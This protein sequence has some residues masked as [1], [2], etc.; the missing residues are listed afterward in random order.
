MV[1]FGAT[2][3]ADAADGPSVRTARARL[4]AARVESERAAL[5]YLSNQAQLGRIEA[6]IGVL[7]QRIPRVELRIRELRT[8]LKERAAVLYRGGEGAGVAVVDTVL[9]GGDL[10]VGGRIA[11]LAGVAH[12]DTD[13]AA[14]ELDQRKAELTEDQ[15]ELVTVRQLQQ[16]LVEDSFAHSQALV[17]KVQRAEGELWRAEQRQALAHY[18]AAVAAQRA[19]HEAA[20]A[21]AAYNG[22]PPP[23]PQEQS[24]PGDPALAAEI[25]VSTLVCPIDGLV[26]FVDDWGQPRSSWRVHQGTD[27][28]NARS[29]PNL[30]VANGV[31]RMRVG[32]LGGNSIWLVTDDGH[33]YYYAHLERFE[34]Q[35][36]PDGTRRVV[37]GDVVGYSGNTGNAAG[38]PVHTHFQIH[39]RAGG[40]I[41]PYAPLREMCK[42]QAGLVPPED[43]NALATTTTLPAPV[44]T[45]STLP[46]ATT[47]TPTTAEGNGS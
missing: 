25:P 38:G 37:R 9:R 26:T 30:A 23:E 45:T 14:D 31:A 28:F 10:M 5:T 13:A 4:E 17:A 18:R 2:A 1:A 34:G 29:T 32:G 35:F 46:T 43:V 24:P 22:A 21:A 41:N 16:I 3:P 42:V 6:R 15:E 40:P 27:I 44:T 47:T 20:A 11:H 39:P 12:A 7:E 8:I 33:A 19:A 36:G